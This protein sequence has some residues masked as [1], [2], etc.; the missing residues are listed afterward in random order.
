MKAI[1]HIGTEKTGTTSIQEFLYQ[2][3]NLLREK[4]YH[5]IQSAGKKNHRQLVAYCLNDYRNDEFF[6]INKINTGEEKKRFKEDLLNKFE[7]EILSLPESIHTVIISSEHFHSRTKTEEEVK[8][9]HTLLS[10]YFTDIKIVCYVREQVKMCTSLYSTAIKAGN[11]PLFDDFLKK[12]APKNIYYNYSD[13]LFNWE[14]AFG[15]EAID[16]S[17]FEKKEFL[18]HDLLD[19]FIAKIDL[20]LVGI[21][22][23]NISIENES[24]TYPGQILGKAINQV[25]SQKTKFDKVKKIR[26]KCQKII[27]QKCKGTGEQAS[28]EEQKRIYDLFFESNEALRK[29]YFPGK[30]ILFQAPSI[31][32]EVDKT[33]NDSF[34]DVLADILTLAKEDDREIAIP[35]RYASVLRD[36]AIKLEKESPELSLKLMSLAHKIRPSGHFIKQKLEEYKQLLR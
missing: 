28:L 29:K 9:A 23:K 8:N 16:V 14:K 36:A 15:R 27:Y 18:N 17:L 10:P 19:D 34:I 30:E 12:C 24:L 6:K 22:D 2:N 5:F 31:E 26:K 11:N 1:I 32:P 4:G 25:F 33:I 20:D 35:V 21:L 7:E 3:Q 13:M